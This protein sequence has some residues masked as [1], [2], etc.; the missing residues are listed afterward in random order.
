[1]VA[2]SCIQAIGHVVGN[3]LACSS[4]EAG[5]AIALG[6]ADIDEGN[7]VLE[8]TN[9]VLPFAEASSFLVVERDGFAAI[10]HKNLPIDA[11]T[12]AADVSLATF[13]NVSGQILTQRRLIRPLDRRAGSR[14]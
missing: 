4:V 14:R 3:D 10:I 9:V 6:P 8:R 1:M 13:S 12:D 2:S 11:T 7:G 5:T